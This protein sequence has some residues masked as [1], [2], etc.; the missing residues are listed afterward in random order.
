MDSILGKM[1]KFGDL[2]VGCSKTL[3]TQ[4][5]TGSP[6]TTHDSHE[7]G[8]VS[9]EKGAQGQATLPRH[10]EV[11]HADPCV[12]LRLPLAPAQQFV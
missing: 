9:M 7:I 12:A 1:Y 4:N 11:R 8:A 5:E 3:G 2:I 6:A 10:G